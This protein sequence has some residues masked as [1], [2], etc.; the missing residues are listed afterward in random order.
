MPQGLPNRAIPTGGCRGWGEEVE[1]RRQRGVVGASHAGI[2]RQTGSPTRG[3]PMTTLLAPSDGSRSPAPNLAKSEAFYSELFNWS[4]SD[5]PTG[6]VYRI[7]DAGDGPPAGSPR[8]RPG[9]LRPTP[10]SMSSCPTSPPPAIAWSS[11]AGRCSSAR[12][13]WRPGSPSPTSKTPMAT[14]SGCSA[15]L[16]R[17]QATG[18]RVRHV[19]GQS[20]NV[21]TLARAGRGRRTEWR[22]SNRCGHL[23]CAGDRRAQRR[24]QG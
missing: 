23:G 16:P 21:L 19:W 1:E 10:S 24:V 20:P 2:S 9:C 14:I 12:R 8:R 22:R 5:G 17:E 7:A 13:R 4:F 3:V 11:W 18:P 6:P 15:L